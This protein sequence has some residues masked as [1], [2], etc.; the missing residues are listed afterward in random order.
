MEEMMIFKPTKALEN[1]LY[2]LP[3]LKQLYIPD[4]VYSKIYPNESI[5]SIFRNINT[6]HIPHS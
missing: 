6:C 3:F 4:L 5:C 1:Y 2:S